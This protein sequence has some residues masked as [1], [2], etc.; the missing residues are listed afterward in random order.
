VTANGANVPRV[1]LG[2]ASR[3][4]GAGRAVLLRTVRL[5]AGGNARGIHPRM[6]SF[7]RILAP[8]DGVITERNAERGDLAIL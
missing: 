6:Q 5:L 3:P 1:Q 4:E 2:A 8:F 7:E